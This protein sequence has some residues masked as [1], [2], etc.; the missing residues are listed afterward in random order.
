MSIST[1]EP[2]VGRWYAPRGGPILMM[3]PLTRQ[4]M[5]RATFV[6]GWVRPCR[7]WQQNEYVQE[8][9]W[10]CT[11]NDYED[12]VEE[13]EDILRLGSREWRWRRMVA[14]VGRR[15][16]TECQTFGPATDG[17]PP[18]AAGPMLGVGKSSF[19]GRIRPGGSSSRAIRTRRCTG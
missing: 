3:D 7:G 17:Q 13:W 19:A 11:L 18:P 9:I 2:L 8:F 4:A 12:V 1:Y 16:P 15:Q 10:A 5:V 6:K 14:G